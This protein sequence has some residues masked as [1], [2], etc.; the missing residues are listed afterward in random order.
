MAGED[1]AAAH[2]VALLEAIR[3][4][5]YRYDLYQALRWLECAHPDQPRWGES[6]HAQDDSL[7]LGQEPSMAFAPTQLAS[8]D[9]GSDGRPARL[10][11][12]HPGLFG[13]NGPLPFHLTEFARER[14]VNEGDDTFA[15]FA[16][17]FH[18]R[19]LALFYRAW[20]SAQPAVQYDRPETDRIALV[21]GALVGMGSPTSR[22]AAAWLDRGLLH[23]SG[24]LAIPTRHAEGL[25]GLLADYYKAHVRIET[26]V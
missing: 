10:R 23:H 15:R 1:G 14:Q 7:R 24:G 5:P 18:H 2:P 11:V 26:F 3:E 21:L 17:I 19:M 9:P 6:R 20:S 8:F 16:D 25:A 4:A 12:F 13:P 22:G